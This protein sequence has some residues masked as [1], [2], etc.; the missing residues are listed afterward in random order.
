MVSVKGTGAGLALVPG[1]VFLRAQH[2]HHRHGSILGRGP[3][4]HPPRERFR[5][6][7]G[8]LAGT[9]EPDGMGITDQGTVYIGVP[10]RFAWLWP[11]AI[12]AAQPRPRR[13]DPTAAVVL[14]RPGAV[15]AADNVTSR[16]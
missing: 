5:E 13:D 14:A 10:P 3:F 1:D 6:R 8:R 2:K 9:V 15:M 16:R 12:G 4:A 11:D 7:G